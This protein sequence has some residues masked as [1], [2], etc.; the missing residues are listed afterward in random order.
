MIHRILQS[1]IDTTELWYRLKDAVPHWKVDDSAVLMGNGPSAGIP[2][3]FKTMCK[4]AINEI[5]TLT[6]MKPR[7]IMLNRL[8]SGVVVPIHTDTVIDDPSRYH[9]PLV[10][11]P[12]HCFFWD[13]EGGIQFMEQGWWYRVNQRIRHTIGNFG[14]NER[15]HLVLDLIP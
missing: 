9:L 8:P 2:E 13:E 15:V 7:H 5:V 4:E 14:P 1:Q 10:T 3:P 12:R 11:D 6:A